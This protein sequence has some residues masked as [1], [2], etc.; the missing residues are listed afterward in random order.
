MV[1]EDQKTPQSKYNIIRANWTPEI[2]ILLHAQMQQQKYNNQLILRI[3]QVNLRLDNLIQF[4]ES[5]I[6]IK[7][8][9]GHCCEQQNNSTLQTQQEFTAIKQYYAMEV[10]FSTSDNT[11]HPNPKSIQA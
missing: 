2:T 5:Q 6:L 9:V 11:A 3:S 1:Q 8:L 4:A 7:L 10:L